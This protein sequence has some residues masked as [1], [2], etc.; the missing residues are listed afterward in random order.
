MPRLSNGKVQETLEPLPVE[1]L[2]PLRRRERVA[3]E[4]LQS[5][6]PRGGPL[7]Q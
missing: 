6:Q 3:E 5:V 4:L 1:R 2:F 7:F